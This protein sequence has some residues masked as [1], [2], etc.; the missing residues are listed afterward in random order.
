MKLEKVHAVITGGGSGMGRAAAEALVAAGGKV[1]IVDFNKERC[2]EVVAQLG[3]NAYYEFADV[4]D[5]KRAEEIVHGA[6]EK[7]G[8]VNVVINCAGM[9]SGT[10]ILPRGGGVFPIETFKRVLDINLIGTFNYICHGALAISQAPECED[11]ERGVINSTTSLSIS[12]GQIGQAAYAAS[13]GGV[14]SMTLPIARELARFGIRVNTICPGLIATNMTSIEAVNRPKDP[15]RP[16]PAGGLEVVAAGD[17]V[18]PQR[19]GTVS[20][21]ASLALEIIRNVH[22]NGASFPIDGAIRFSPKW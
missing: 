6:V 8:Y 9:G 20:E 19:Q 13:K 15:N 11:G 4:S 22:L 12:H 7:F 2:E 3:E 18:F 1:C 17:F 14:H 10:R 21:F 5:S 16:P